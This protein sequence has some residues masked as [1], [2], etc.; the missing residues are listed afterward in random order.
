MMTV[1]DV[2]VENRVLPAVLTI[3]DFNG[4]VLFKTALSD[5]KTRL[6]I[7]GR[8]QKLAINVTPTNENYY[9]STRFID[10]CALPCEA[11]LTLA[12]SLR[13][14]PSPAPQEFFLTDEKYSFPIA[15]AIMYFVG[16]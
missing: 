12:F 14:V 4:D 13:Q 15:R 6:Y 8:P 1:I 7:C 16:Q 3:T 2:F 5:V 10:L 9:P 11:K